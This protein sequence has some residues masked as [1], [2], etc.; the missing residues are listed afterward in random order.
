M[1]KMFEYLFIIYGMNCANVNIRHFFTGLTLMIFS[2]FLIFVFYLPNTS[3]MIVMKIFTAIIFISHLISY[4]IIRIKSE[5]IFQL[6]YELKAYRTEHLMN[7][8]KN[9]YFS[10]ISLAYL[11]LSIATIAMLTFDDQFNDLF[12]SLYFPTFFKLS[13]IVGQFYQHGWNILIQFIYYELYTQYNNIIESF[14]KELR[15]KNTT[16]SKN[17]ILMTQRNISNFIRFQ[18]NLKSNISFITYF[19]TLNLIAF[20]VYLLCTL[21]SDP[22]LD[23]WSS[24]STIFYVIF[25]ILYFIWIRLSVSK[26]N[27]I[28]ENMIKRLHKWQNFRRNRE[29]KIELLA[30]KREIQKFN[31]NQDEFEETVV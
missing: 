27:Q 19:I 1:S 14:N 23:S 26:K 25:S 5:Q 7:N 2:L 13:S 18:S 15:E 16:P 22:D 28:E 3:I 29:I 10:I 9:I 31:R 20:N 6:Y 24:S 12:K 4:F 30:L 8:S 21:I 11:I 17:V